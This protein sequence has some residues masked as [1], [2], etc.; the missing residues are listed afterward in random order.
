[1]SGDGSH[2][3]KYKGTHFENYFEDYEN[4]LL[5]DLIMEYLENIDLAEV[6]AKALKAKKFAE[7]NA[8]AII[9][10]LLAIIALISIIAIA[11]DMKKLRELKK[12]RK[13]CKAKVINFDESEL[14]Y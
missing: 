6:K 3:I 12:L 10:A 8:P 5:E 7:E 11:V 14:P 2:F 13:N 4:L 9:I 1:L